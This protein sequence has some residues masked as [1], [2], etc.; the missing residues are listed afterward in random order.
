LVLDQLRTDRKPSRK[1]DK[2]MDAVI[3]SYDKLTRKFKRV[4]K[5][6]VQ[7]TKKG[8]WDSSETPNWMRKNNEVFFDKDGKVIPK[9]KYADFVWTVPIKVPKFYKEVGIE[10]VER[11]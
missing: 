10:L 3:G 5:V 9:E 11:K 1:I 2:R 7:L 4:H 8:S 6:E